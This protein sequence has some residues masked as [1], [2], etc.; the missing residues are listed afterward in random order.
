[1][2]KKKLHEKQAKDLEEC[3]F[4]PNRITKNKDRKYQERADKSPEKF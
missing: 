2:K 4:K 3:S 1:M